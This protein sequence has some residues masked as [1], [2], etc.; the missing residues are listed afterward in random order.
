[1]QAGTM[2]A[3]LEAGIEPDLLVGTSVGAL[4]AAFLS[5]RPGVGGA[6]GLVTAWSALARREGFRFNLFTA[7]AGFLGLRDHLVSAQQ[8]RQLID[9][10]SKSTE[11]NMHQRYSPLLPP[12]PLAVRQ[13]C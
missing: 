10:G 8:F 12:M 4:N 9:D 2:L 13:W 6:R 3:L 1:M 11:S 5:T 7:L